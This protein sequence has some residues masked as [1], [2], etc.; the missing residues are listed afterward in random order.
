M[1]FREILEQLIENT[2]PDILKVAL[3]HPNG[4][5]KGNLYDTHYDLLDRIVLHKDAERDYGFIDTKGKY[6]TRVE[7]LVWVKAH[8]PEIYKEYLKVIKKARPQDTE[9]GYSNGLESVGY[10][11]AL[12]IEEY[13]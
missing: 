2:H 6:Y 5:L 10:R 7:A 1:K 3:K 9:F 11:K 4:L 12:G 8:T 13:K